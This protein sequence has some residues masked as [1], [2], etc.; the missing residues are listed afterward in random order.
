MINMKIYKLLFWSF[1]LPFFLFSCNGWL[2]VRPEDEIAEEDVFSSGNGF[3][4]AL[5]G[6][7]YSM[8]SGNMYGMQLTWGVVDALGQVYDYY[9]TSHDLRYGAPDY[10]WSN[11]RFKSVIESMWKETYNVVANCNNLIQQIEEADPEMFYSKNREKS[12]IWGEA[13]ALRAFLQFDML[14][15]F[16]PAPVTNPGARKFT[17]YVDMYPAYVS[18]PKTVEEC[19]TAVIEDLKEAKKLLWKI[20][21]VSLFHTS[22]AFNSVGN[23]VFLSRRGYRLN[24]WA[25]TALLARVYLYAQKENEAL[26]QASEVIEFAIE[27]GIF[28]F[29]DNTSNGDT[30]FYSDVIWGLHVIDLSKLYNVL[31]QPV[32]T[33]PTYLC[34]NEAEDNYFGEDLNTRNDV[35]TSN[36]RRYTYW[37]ED[38]D[39]YHYDYRFKKYDE[40]KSGNL[41]EISNT[42]VVM[43]RMSEVYYIA[44]EVLAKQGGEGLTKAKSYL[45]FVKQGRGLRTSDK[46]VL[47]VDNAS[48]SDAFMN[49]LINDMRRDWI[50]EGQTFYIYK[51]LN[52]DIPSDAY[53]GTVTASE[54]IFVVPLP[55]GET[56]L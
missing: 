37:I 56:N 34:I 35:I 39:N 25:A 36:D 48:S 24:Y 4:H 46:S 21:S 12:G 26:E 30:K 19:L 55:E 47:A 23:D 5:N 53:T 42:M 54:K 33:N 43:I 18:Q 27:K 10:D 49:V 13:L 31:N 16:A 14:R 40:S 41:M 52:K 17:P 11:A 51:R 8:E 22:G 29:K 38:M 44:A 15:L 28:P 2:D 9:W 7:Y 1:I 3:R 32:A 6:I 20:D 50:G 45:K